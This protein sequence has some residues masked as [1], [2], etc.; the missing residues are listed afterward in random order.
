MQTR[1]SAWPQIALVVTL[2]S[3][4][5]CE[6]H[7]GDA[8]TVQCPEPVAPDSGLDA[9]GQDLPS[10]DA[11]IAMDLPEPDIDVDTPEEDTEED[12][13]CRRALPT[14][15]K[16]EFDPTSVGRESIDSNAPF[17]ATVI[18]SCFRTPIEEVVLYLQSP[19]TVATVTNIEVDGDTALAEG[20]S[21]DWLG[22]VPPGTYGVTVH[23]RSATESLTQRDMA[24]V[25]LAEGGD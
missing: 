7:S 8:E 23:V 18:V 15:E 17:A 16:L 2:F 10:E 5:A 22:E 4:T 9:T 24:I 20:P 25:A 13:S 19:T 21:G 6:Q 14:I 1:T 3:L 12:N 11:D